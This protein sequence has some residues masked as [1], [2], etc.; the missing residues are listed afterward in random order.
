[1]FNPVK[2]TSPSN[3]SKPFQVTKLSK[4]LDHARSLNAQSVKWP[5]QFICPNPFQIAKQARGLNQCKFPNW[6]QWPIQIECPGNSILPNCQK[7]LSWSKCPNWW[8]WTIHFTRP[9]HSK[10][11]NYQK[12]LTSLNAQ[13]GENDQ[14][15]LHVQTIP[16]HQS[17][18]RCKVV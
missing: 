5:V 6:W 11:P 3:M 10:S 1:M 7:G 15:A 4:G 17:S 2:M 18:K 16:N 13:T 12:V 9:D 8:K 14:S